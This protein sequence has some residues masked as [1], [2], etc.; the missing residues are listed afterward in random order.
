M[1]K[2][3][4]AFVASAV[5]LV[6]MLPAVALAD[7]ATVLRVLG[8]DLLQTPTVTC[9][10]G[11]ASYDAATNTLTLEGATINASAGNGIQFAGPLTIR[12]VGANEIVADQR[13]IYGNAVEQGSVTLTGDPGATLTVTSGYE[14]VQIDDTTAPAAFTIDGVTLNVTSTGRS[15]LV[16]EGLALM[17]ENEADVSFATQAQSSAV[18]TDANVTVSGQSSLTAEGEGSYGVRVGGN[19]AVEDAEL[20]ATSDAIAALVDGDI[21]IDGATVSTTS[22]SNSL[23]TDT[24]AITV[25]GD[26][27][28]TA[29]GGVFG[30]MGVTVSPVAGERVDVWAGASEAEATHYVS[31]DGTQKS[32]FA[33]QVTINSYDA[34][35]AN[36]FVRILR[37]EHSGAGATCT[38]LAVC[39]YCGD[40]YGTLDL[41]N[42]VWGEPVFRWYEGGKVCAA[43]FPCE[44]DPTHV[45]LM[46]ATVSSAAG[47][48]PTCTEAG[49]TVYTATVSFEGTTHTATTETADVA[50]LGHKTEL[51]GARDATALAEGYTG[52]HV[53]TVCGVT[54]KKGEVIAR[55][56]MGTEVMYRL[57]NQWTGEH[58]YTGSLEEREVLIT[59]GWTDEGIG[60]VAPVEG[61][62]V[63]RLYN[64]YVEGGDHHYTMNE[65]EYRAL[66]QLGWKQE[67]I[68]WYSAD[69]K[70]VAAL[71]VYRQYNPYAATGTHNYTQSKAENDALVG[72]GWKSEGIAWYA[73]EPL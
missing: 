48:A 19:L 47:K 39:Q 2:R 4:L 28:V 22:T 42:H 60:W 55:L 14:G 16:L 10:S 38:Q 20:T 57:Y 71:P 21:T 45:K 3:L 59:V 24:G 46:D 17:V 34:L 53:C 56:P 44:L 63:Y 23:R 66:A 40:T 12:L 26:S 33:A 11:T 68:C 50:A 15:G 49:T 7:G 29:V 5:A 37:H 25:T 8:Q 43:A 64:P 36:D 61:A 41:A 35:S 32:P 62:P 67:G 54:V 69:E 52:D 31:L 70:G 30:E 65:D 1:K 58:F 18:R 13:G 6:V 51:V 27:V 73:V 9:G 72:A